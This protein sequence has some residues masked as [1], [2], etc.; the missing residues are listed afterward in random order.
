MSSPSIQPRAQ[1][2]LPWGGQAS[3]RGPPLSALRCARH[4]GREGGPPR[5]DPGSLLHCKGGHPE[6]WRQGGS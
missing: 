5:P 1:A 6:N 4:L 3:A 2:L